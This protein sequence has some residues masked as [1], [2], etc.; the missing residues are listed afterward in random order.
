RVGAVVWAPVLGNDRDHFGIAAD[1]VAYPRH[2]WLPGVQ[3]NAGRERGPNPQVA[4]FEL[5]QKLAAQVWE[6]EGREDEDPQ[7]QG[8]DDGAILHGT[9]QQDDV[10]RPYG[11]DDERLRL[12]HGVR[13][14]EG[15]EHGGH[16]KRRQEGAHQSIA[17][18]FRHRR[19]DLSFDALHGKE[20]N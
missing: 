10:E 7:R 13:Q 20:R 11:P 2:G 17:V 6:D 5:R 8:D 12:P 1:D 14:Q 3:G 19:E 16:G 18:R 9:L 15:G 4:L